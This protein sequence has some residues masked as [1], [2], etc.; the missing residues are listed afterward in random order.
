MKRRLVANHRP[1]PI[2]NGNTSGNNNVG[3]NQ[4]RAQDLNGSR[5]TYT[6]A[7]A[8]PSL[9]DNNSRTALLSSDDVRTPLHHPQTH[10]HQQHQR[11][12]RQR[13][14]HLHTDSTAD[15]DDVASHSTIDD[16]TPQT[17]SESASMAELPFESRFKTFVKQK[18]NKVSSI[19]PTV[20]TAAVVTGSGA[21]VATKVIDRYDKSLPAAPSD[22]DSEDEESDIK[23][24]SNLL[25]EHYADALPV[26]TAPSSTN[27]L[28][29]LH[30]HRE[31]PINSS[32]GDRSSQRLL[33]E[34]ESA[35][36][37][38]SSVGDSQNDS[39]QRS[40]GEYDAVNGNESVRADHN[41]NNDQTRN[42]N[43]RTRDDDESEESVDDD[44]EDAEEGVYD[45]GASNLFLD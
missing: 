10:H 1:L 38:G 7:N 43:H 6:S 40:S 24:S 32:R 3:A 29:H 13:S 27:Q 9:N 21:T 33:S 30:H 15:Y 26:R 23:P 37:N 28:G 11:H 39:R 36:Q 19:N 2:K 18:K 25:S 12:K 44:E 16:T 17:S 41:N 35:N 4:H 34:T 42:S 14:A 31:P 20:S 22:V 5:T 8:S 45:L